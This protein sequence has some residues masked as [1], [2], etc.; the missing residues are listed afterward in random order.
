LFD[1]YVVK[2]EKEILSAGVE[3][4]LNFFERDIESAGLIEMTCKVIINSDFSIELEPKLLDDILSDIAI[5]KTDKIY[6][7][8]RSK[9]KD[10]IFE[11]I[12]KTI[13]II[14]GLLEKVFDKKEM[15]LK[16]K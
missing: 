1:N 10:E 16:R 11:N 2:N 12:I 3:N 8:S 5:K 4:T 6:V 9:H 14:F 13:D 7:I 15:T